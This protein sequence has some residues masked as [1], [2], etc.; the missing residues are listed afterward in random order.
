MTRGKKTHSAMTLVPEKFGLMVIPFTNTSLVSVVIE[1]K[2]GQETYLCA[3]EATAKQI[4]YHW[5]QTY[6]DESC[7]DDD[8]PKNMDAAIQMYFSDHPDHE[9]YTIT[10]HANVYT[11]VNGVVVPHV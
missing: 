11:R 3:D 2:H 7:P 1:H 4:L 6:W 5:A 10:D 8:I 9:G